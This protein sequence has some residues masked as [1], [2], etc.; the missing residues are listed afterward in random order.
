MEVIMRH[1]PDCQR[2]R[3]YKPLTM[4]GLI[5]ALYC[6]FCGHTIELQIKRQRG[7]R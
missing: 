7:K 6:V 1:C 3:V 2:L 5:V 4:N